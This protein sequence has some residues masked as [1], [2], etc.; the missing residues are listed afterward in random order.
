MDVAHLT[1]LIESIEAEAK[2]P[3][4]SHG[5]LARLTA[6]ALRAIL[7]EAPTATVVA[8]ASTV[9][10]GGTVTEQPANQE[11]PEESAPKPS[12][13]KPSKRSGNKA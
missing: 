11:K 5:N 7:A 3:A 8:P 12:R 10:T 1:G 9:G 13:S 6:R 4:P 2:Q